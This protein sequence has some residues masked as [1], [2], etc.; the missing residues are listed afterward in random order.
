MPQIT[1]IPKK[2]IYLKLLKMEKEIKELKELLE[3]TKKSLVGVFH[4]RVY[5]GILK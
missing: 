5:G 1:R 3:G 2:E 4:S